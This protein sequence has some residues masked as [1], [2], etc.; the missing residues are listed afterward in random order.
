[1]VG[2]VDIYHLVV[3][4]SLAMMPLILLL[5][6]PGRRANREVLPVME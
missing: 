4:V 6:T 3:I 1:M 2:N 5:R